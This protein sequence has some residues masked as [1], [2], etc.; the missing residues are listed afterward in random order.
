ML[1]LFQGDAIHRVDHTI[2]FVT[3]Y[4]VLP[5]VGT[6][7]DEARRFRSHSQVFVAHDHPA[8]EPGAKS[9]RFRHGHVIKS[10]QN[11]LQEMLSEHRET[12]FDKLL[13]LTVGWRTSPDN[14]T[15]GVSKD[16]IDR[17]DLVLNGHLNSGL[18]EHL[19]L[20]GSA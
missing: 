5:A 17:L 18:G 1:I 16:G 9:T 11:E 7:E 14:G 19:S 6:D 13:E 20:S 4:H 12:A 15:V 3:A 8:F 10:T 2:G